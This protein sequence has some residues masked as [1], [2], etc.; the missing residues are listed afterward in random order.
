MKFRV[1]GSGSSAQVPC[2]GCDCPACRRARERPEWRRGPATAGIHVQGTRYLIDAGR[3]DLVETCEFMRPE[4]FLITHY[5]ADHVQ[6]LLRLRWGVGPGI[7]VYG[8]RDD[9]GFDGLF[10]TSGLLEFQT[11]LEPFRPLQLS[12]RLDVVPVPLNH[13]KPVLGYCLQ[14]P[15]GRLAYLTDTREI[16]VETQ[17]FLETWQPGIV[18]LDATLPPASQDGNHNTVPEALDIVERLSPT[19]AWLTHLSHDVDAAV[20]DGTLIL[21]DGVEL[22]H[23]GLEFTF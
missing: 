18:I 13:S 7:P 9:Q 10:E 2:F 21:P 23:D 15:I 19:Q 8:P 20:M 17:R 16:P 6:G 5:H 22:A 14:G 11:G 3:T 4:A 12:G 1:T